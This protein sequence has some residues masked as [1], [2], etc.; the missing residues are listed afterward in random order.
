MSTQEQRVQS[1][2]RAIDVGLRKQLFID[3]KFIE[4]QRGITLRMNPPVKAEPVLVVEAPWEQLGLGYPN[5]VEKDGEYWMYYNTCFKFAKSLG[6]AM[7]VIANVEDKTVGVTCLAVSKDGLAWQRKNV[8][9]FDILGNKNN[10]IVLPECC[11]TVFE[12]P[13][14]TDGFPYWFFGIMRENPWWDGAK[15]TTHTWSPM[16]GS[17]HLARSRDGLSWERVPGYALPFLCDTHNQMFWDAR[18]NKYVFYVRGWEFPDRAGDYGRVVCRGE[19]DQLLKLP[20]PFQAN[21]NRK[22]GLRGM[23]GTVSAELPIVM[24]CDK[25]DPPVTDLYN[26]CVNRYAEAEDV[27]LSFPSPYRHYDAKF[28]SHGRDKRGHADDKANDGPVDIACAVSRDGV[29]WHRFRE[30]Y[31]RLGLIGEMDGGSIYMGIGLVVK[32]NEIWQYNC[33]VEETHGNYLHKQKNA[34]I[35]VVQR[36]DGFVSADTG[37]EGG[38]ITTPVVKFAGNRLRLN[39]DCGAM[40]EAWVEIQDEQ[41]SPI[42]GFTMAESVSVDRNGV[43]QEVWWQKGPD[44]AS[45]TGK[46]VRLHIKMRSAKLYAFQFGAW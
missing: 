11:G 16:E 32:D 31:V 4:K 6:Q 33:A 19:T 10:N 40:G 15:G 38:E 2:I 18:L 39:I 7:N 34:I 43:A 13:S 23:Y 17:L 9:H 5:V 44:L 20:W 37:P 45:L 35:R 3:Q 25:E 30:P 8:G 12:D 26:P 41:G 27:Y 46:P 21:P 24:R 22:T 36:L 1:E 14:K 29:I 42:P 28:N